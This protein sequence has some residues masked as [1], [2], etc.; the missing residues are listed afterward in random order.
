MAR[1][2]SELSF[3][4][5]DRF[6]VAPCVVGSSVAS[7]S[8]A[9]GG[10]AGL[11][12]PPESVGVF[13]ESFCR[14]GPR[15]RVNPILQLWLVPIS[16]RD[17]SANPRYSYYYFTLEAGCH[18]LCCY[19]IGHLRPVRSVYIGGVQSFNSVVVFTTLA[20][21]FSFH[22]ILFVFWEEHKL[23]L[24]FLIIVV[25]GGAQAST[26]FSGRSTGFHLIIGEEHKLQLNLFGEEHKFQ[27]SCR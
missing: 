15:R 13:R 4:V 11:L 16:I 25:R 5:V 27:L 18:C 23:P 2:V 19:P 22:S 26:R 8:C 21:S 17:C 10:E 12:S 9:M 7:A 6:G 3:F 14:E 1:S 24:D 20:R